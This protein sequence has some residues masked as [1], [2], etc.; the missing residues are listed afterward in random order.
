MGKILALCLL[1]IQNSA[2]IV[3]MRMTRIAKSSNNLYL[4]STAVLLAECMKL[5]LCTIIY[6][7]DRIR[8]KTKSKYSYK[9]KFKAKQE[10]RQ[11]AI[12]PS[13]SSGK[14]FYEEVFGDVEQLKKVSVPSLLYVVQNNLQFMATSNLPAEAYQVLIQ[15]KIISTAIFS[16]KILKRFQS[17]GQWLSILSLSLGAAIVQTS[18]SKV[19][20]NIAEFNPLLGIFAV[21]FSCVTSGLAGA[22]NESALKEKKI[23]LITRNFQMI[24]VSIVMAIFSCLRDWKE[25]AAFGFFKG[26]DQ[27]VFAVIFLQ[28]MGGLITSFVV[29]YTDSIIKVSY[30]YFINYEFST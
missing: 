25:I 26:Y 13:A 15:M 14:S 21:L 23:R 20:G 17:T 3:C 18:F 30:L 16:R 11:Y 27:N 12:K 5:I 6:A 9:P 28:A 2:L 7:L 24:S 1:V 4:S 22:Y 10:P 29:K 8:K 19:S